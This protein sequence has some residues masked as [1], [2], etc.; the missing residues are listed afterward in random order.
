MERPLDVLA[1]ETLLDI[2][3]KSDYSSLIQLSRT[4]HRL[5]ALLS[6]DSFCRDY[7]LD[8]IPEVYHFSGPVEG[9][10]WC[11]MLHK[12][13]V[14]LRLV[15][16]LDQLRR[17]ADQ[18]E[19]YMLIVTVREGSR[20]EFV[21]MT[22]DEHVGGRVDERRPKGVD[23]ILLVV[24]LSRRE[25]YYDPYIAIPLLIELAFTGRILGTQVAP[26]SIRLTARGGSDPTFYF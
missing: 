10:T 22:Y 25:E 6:D 13:P 23:K 9:L 14:F 2:I 7:F 21:R 1:D 18:N 16:I 8:R 4:S 26:H 15:P 5:R 19:N 11:Q 12:L 20:A 24:G 3:R 17:L